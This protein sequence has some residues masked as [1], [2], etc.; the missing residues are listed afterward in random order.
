MLVAQEFDAATLALDP[1]SHQIADPV[2]SVGI[3]NQMNVAVSAGGL[4][5]Y[6][7]FNTRGQFTWI[8]HPAAPEKK[9]PEVIGEPDEYGAF[10][11]SPNGLNIATMRNRPSGIDISLVAVDR[12]IP[13][14]F[15]LNSSTALFPVW[16][17]GGQT[18][19]FTPTPSRNLHCKDSGGAGPERRLIPSPNPQYAV[20][21]SGDGHWVLYWENTSDTGRDLWLLPVTPDGK[22]AP[23]TTP[24]P[25]LRTPAN[26]SGGRFSPDPGTPRWVAYQSDETGPYEVYID[27]FPQPRDKKMISKGGGTYPQW[28]AGGHQLFYVSPNFRLMVVDLKETANGLEP[29]VPKELFRLPAVDIGYSPY[30]VT[31]DGQR[32]LVLATPEHGASQPLTVIVNWPALLKDGKR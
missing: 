21:W 1:E 15:T 7:A 3:V 6:S 14:R 13:S 20:D 12:G 25:Y 5:L 18:I 31:P 32:F 10:R 9:P 11:L 16:S 30:D 8:D 29:S 28:G 23:D 27:A 22:P 19:L 24:R 2:T 26:E 4:L 17:P